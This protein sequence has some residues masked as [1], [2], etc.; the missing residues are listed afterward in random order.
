M[1]NLSKFN[2]VLLVFSVA[3]ILFSG[4]ASPK[5]Q[6]PASPPPA[7]APVS[8]PTPSAPVEKVE[9]TIS[10]AASLT[11]ALKEIQTN[12][13]GKNK[14]I[15][16]NFN[17]GASGALQQQIE[18]GA[19]A[20]LFLSAAT[21]NMKTLVDKQL[22]DASQQKNLLINELV[23][24]T[25]DDGKIAIQKIEDLTNEAI[26]HL[27]VGEP[28]TVPAGSYAKEALTSSKLWD[29]LQPR[30]VQ[31]KDV[32]QVLTYV[33]SGNAEAGFVYKTDAL[34]SKKVKVAFSVDSKLYTPIE[35]PAGIVKSTKHSKEA[36]DFYTYL[37]SK[38][39]QDVFVKYGFTVPK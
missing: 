8:Q 3:S 21:K 27:A 9:L 25:P 24:V 30:I 34:T 29:S 28:Q 18:Q 14:Q 17:F 16:L 39:S 38:E 31:G 23:V 2:H 10:A 11:D 7:P 19:P 33:E 5:E 15:K 4:C 12:Y 35:Y 20:D 32:R 6:T 26:K 1:L 36:A 22:I 13:E 37:Q